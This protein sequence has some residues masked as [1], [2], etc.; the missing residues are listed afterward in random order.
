MI[1]KLIDKLEK[2]GDEIW[3]HFC[4]IRSAKNKKDFFDGLKGIAKIIDGCF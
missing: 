2:Q 1:R 3:R 4:K